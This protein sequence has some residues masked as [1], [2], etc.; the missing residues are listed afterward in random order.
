M[1]D[2]KK[3]KDVKEQLVKSRYIAQRY[4]EIKS[5]RGI[6]EAEQWLGMLART[7]LKT[8]KEEA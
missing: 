8:L 6:S 1:K 7:V 5:T 3:L 4:R 2:T